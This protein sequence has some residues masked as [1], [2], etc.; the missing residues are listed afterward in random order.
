MNVLVTGSSGLIGSALVAL[1]GREGH[2]VTRLV[3]SPGEVV[4]QSILWDPAAGTI[5]PSALEGTEVA[6]H[7][8]GE[9]VAGRWT[10]Q[11][12][13]RIRESRVSSTRLLSRALADLEPKPRV[14]VSASATG[15]YGDRADEPLT[16]ESPPG[17]G[18]L[19]DVVHEWEA[20]TEPARAAGIRVVHI[21]SGI[22]LSPSGGALA[23]MLTPFRLGLG[24]RLGNGR[25]YMSWIGLEDEVRAIRHAMLNPS[26]AGPINL[27]APNP[28][29]NREFA[30]TLGR[31]LGRPAVLPTPTLPLALLFGREFVREALLASARVLPRRLEASGFEFEHPEL[32]GALRH[33]LA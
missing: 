26:L 29:T 20:A 25:H 19:A 31:V 11:K 18:F 7:L 32:E 3:R 22:V 14:L 12:K 1:L 10:P 16:E 23:R 4:H 24:G 8:A 9:T 33:M 13:R 17:A 2:S 30:K 15:Y 6:V 27:V 5:D 21:R 28:V